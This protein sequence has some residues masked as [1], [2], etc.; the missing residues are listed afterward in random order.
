MTLVQGTDEWR[1]ARAGSLGAS[2]IHEAVARTKTGWGSSRTNLAARL[3]IE[4]LTGEPM[5]SYVNAAMQHGIDT[6]PMARIAYEFY[7]NVKVDQVG[8]IIHPDI[9]GTHASPDGLVGEDGLV[10]IKA[11]QP[12]QHLATLS[13]GSIPEKYVIQMQW[14]MRCCNRHWCDFISFSPVFPESMRLFVKRV[15]RDDD[16][17]AE[18]EGEVKE[19]LSEVSAKV[20]ALRSKYEPVEAEEFLHPLMAG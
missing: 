19:F 1:R 16:R 17:I 10:E 5:E 4:R 18:L 13:G 9:G 12:A 7:S 8:L 20:E 15:D 3:V 2:Q 11:P 14:Q 6:E